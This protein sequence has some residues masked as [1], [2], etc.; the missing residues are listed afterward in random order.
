[1]TPGMEGV[2]SVAERGC[3]HGRE[4]RAMSVSPQ[5]DSM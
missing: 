4:G 1:M 3:G 5:G 2:A